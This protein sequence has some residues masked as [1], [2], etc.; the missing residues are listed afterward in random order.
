MHEH[1]H[2]HPVRGRRLA[3][4][5]GA[6]RLLLAVV[7]LQP[8]A[9][10]FADSS[11]PTSE[12]GPPTV[13]QDRRININEAGAEELTTLPGIGPSRAEAILAERNKRRFRRPEDIMRVPGIGR[14]TFARIRP[15]IR[16]R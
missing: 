7:V 15:L 14:K 11:A 1:R 10:A 8:V 2:G 12:Q 3:W 4:L 13:E 6:L 9:P 5:G 16:V